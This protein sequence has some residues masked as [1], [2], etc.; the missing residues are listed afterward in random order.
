[1]TMT[2]LLVTGASGHLGQ[3]VLHHL[4]DTLNVPAGRVIA[5]TRKPDNLAAWTLRGIIVRGADFDDEASLTRAFQ[6]ADRMLL[7]S[8]DATMAE[9]RMQQHQRAIT[10]AEKAGVGHVTYTSMPDPKRSL[11]LFAPDHA[12]SEAALAASK[13]ASWKVLRNHWYF[14]NLFMLLP[15]VLAR[16]GKWFSAAGDGKMADIARDDV[17]LAAA[18]ELA[19]F[20][21]GKTIYTVSGP[22][23]LTTAE[24][25]RLISASIGKPIQLIPVS[26]E[27]LIRGMVAAGIPEESARLL[28]SFDANVAA[29]HMGNVSGDFKKIT[30]RKPRSFADWLGANRA[31]L[32]SL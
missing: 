10:A 31:T 1:M 21:S 22:E 11:V 29:G 15:G 23:A 26:P 18:H 14:E 5:T 7:V 25:V 17:A 19:S 9:R 12:A 32:A 8:T 20:S 4:L 3:R 6:G 28:T 30:R 16:G 27:N 24:Q 2:T 13:L